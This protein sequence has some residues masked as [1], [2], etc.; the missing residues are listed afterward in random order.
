MIT[1]KIKTLTLL[2]LETRV[3]LKKEFR[4]EIFFDKKATA[5][6]LHL[7]TKTVGNWIRDDNRPSLEQLHKLR[8]DTKSDEFFGNIDSVGMNK[9][10]HKFSL[11]MLIDLQEIAWLLGVMEGDK[12]GGKNRVGLS[13]ENKEI[14]KRFIGILIRPNISKEKIKLKI[15]VTEGDKVNKKKFS[16]EF[17]IK[18]ENIT[19]SESE[20]PRKAPVIQ[21]MINSKLWFCIFQ[22]LRYIA[23]NEL[24]ANGVSLKFIQGFYDAEG[25][26]NVNK[27]TVELKQKNSNNGRKL[28]NFINEKLKSL[29]IRA[30]IN[31]PNC[32]DMLIIRLAGGKRNV[33][34]LKRFSNLIG[35]SSTEKS[36]K[37]KNLFSK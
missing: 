36:N 26:V 3:A 20:I 28:I 33:E 14:I 2:P 32:E 34:N 15:Q 30:S 10:K 9:S 11:P 27:M 13:N 25:S 17:G 1:M 16:E 5:E 35:F 12:A 23:L 19:V 8:V 7:S 29:N 6:K 31:G 37:L 24:I 18:L 22:K 21:A 4:R